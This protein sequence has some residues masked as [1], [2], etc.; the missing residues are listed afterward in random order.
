MSYI[1]SRLESW[2]IL[3]LIEGCSTVFLGILGVI[4]LPD[5]IPKARFLSSDEKEFCTSIFQLIEPADVS[6]VSEAF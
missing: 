2:R 3:F 6:V 4:F 5:D 1:K